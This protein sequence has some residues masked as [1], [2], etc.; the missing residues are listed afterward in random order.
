MERNNTLTI[1]RKIRRY[2]SI[3][4]DKYLVKK[5]LSFVSWVH[6]KFKGTYCWAD[7]V[8]WAYNPYRLNP[9]KIE[10][11]KGCEEESKIHDTGMCY[12]GGWNKGV[13]WEKL[14]KEEKERQLNEIEL[15]RANQPEYLPF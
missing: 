5:K 6:F 8:G 12:C 10:T 13:C 4:H 15:K 7:C 2:W 9:F 1:K 11:S 14:S 3:F